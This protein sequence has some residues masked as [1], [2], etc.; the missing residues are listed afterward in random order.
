M[1]NIRSFIKKYGISI[2]SEWSDENPN[3]H[4]WRDANHYKVK[5]VRQPT[6]NDPHRRQFTTYFSMGYSHTDEPK[7]EDVLDCLAMDTSSYENARDFEEWAAEFGYDTDSRRAE[8]TY[9]VIG[10]QAKQ[11]KRFL[12][13]ELY[14]ELLWNTERL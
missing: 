12:S 11:L 1:N 5:L 9:N 14:E 8:R 3:M 6:K 4:E 7:A 10:K 13:E 2:T